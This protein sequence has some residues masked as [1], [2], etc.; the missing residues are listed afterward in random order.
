[1]LFAG[2]AGFIGYVASKPVNEYSKEVE[3]LVNEGVSK[4]DALEIIKKRIDKDYN[5]ALN[6]KAQSK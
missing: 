1:M 2:F 4:K 6:V 5:E 3:K